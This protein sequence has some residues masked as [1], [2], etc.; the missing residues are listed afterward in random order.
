MVYT[1]SMN[2]KHPFPDRRTSKVASGSKHV[3]LLEKQL[4]TQLSRYMKWLKSP[5]RGKKE[6]EVDVS[7]PKSQI[8]VLNKA[9]RMSKR[10]LHYRPVHEKALFVVEKL[11]NDPF[12]RDKVDLG[13]VFEPF[14]KSAARTPEE[15]K[16][17]RD[18]YWDML[19][20]KQPERWANHM[21][22]MA[23]RE[24]A[25][26]KREELVK[27]KREYVEALEGFRKE[28]EGYFAGLEKFVANEDI[29]NARAVAKKSLLASEP[30]KRGRPRKHPSPEALA[31]AKL[32]LKET[33]GKENANGEQSESGAEQLP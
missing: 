25:I 31:A 29:L 33:E 21:A 14:R 7:L 23:R 12:M 6:M 9:Y 18:A 1:V 11:S 30:K 16:A 27:K 3:T 17:R 28:R 13:Y 15:K 20:V 32:L 19:R 10:I 5:V 4:D 2:A 8:A 26:L 22:L 24:A